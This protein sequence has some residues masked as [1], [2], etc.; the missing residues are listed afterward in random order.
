M[1]TVFASALMMIFSCG[2]GQR[3][4]TSAIAGTETP[5]ET[6]AQ[7]PRQTV[8]SLNTCQPATTPL[9]FLPTYQ[10]ISSGHLKA[11]SLKE[12]SGLAASGIS[13][14]VFWGMNDSGHSPVLYALNQQGDHLGSVSLEGAKN[15]DWEDI[16]AFTWRG[17][18]WLMIADTGDNGLNRKKV[19]LYF[20]KEPTIAEL[21]RTETRSVDS[22][23]RMK[24][25]YPDGPQDIEAAAVSCVDNKVYLVNKNQPH[26]V[27]TLPLEFESG[28]TLRVASKVATISPLPANA[29]DNPLIIAFAGKF[30]LKPTAMDFSDDG[31]LALI[32]NYLHI[33]LFK[34]EEEQTWASAFQAAPVSVI[35]HSL[36]QSEAAS[37]L[38]GSH[39]ILYGTEGRGGEL[40]ISQ[41]Q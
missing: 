21:S 8:I 25:T 33:Y 17:E 3:F 4:Q 5:E 24:F 6:A 7:D 1:A 36:A 9:S 18:P 34:R 13:K 31:R 11:A 16:A 32:A 41:T 35:D 15:K 20:V 10:N 22:W 23:S 38:A 12:L 27:Y 26:T 40:T 19:S 28:D 14:N 37:F 2:A 29:A 39:H 30:L